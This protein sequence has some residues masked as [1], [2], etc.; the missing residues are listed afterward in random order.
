MNYAFYNC[1]N[2]T[3]ITLRNVY[4]NM[5]EYMCQGCTNLINFTIDYNYSDT[6]NCCCSNYAFAQCSNL[7]NINIISSNNTSNSVKFYFR[8]TNHM[9][10]DCSAL[11]KIPFN[12]SHFYS[13]NNCFENCANLKTANINHP[14]FNIFANTFKDTNITKL[15]AKTTGLNI[16]VTMSSAF[17]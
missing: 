17:P 14:S 6:T 12:G 15:D 8:N 2:L 9:F 4:L 7:K 3:S 16:A 5:A 10:Q 1:T 11:T 13:T